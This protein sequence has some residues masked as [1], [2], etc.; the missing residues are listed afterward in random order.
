[1]YG[2]AQ[3]SLA[4]ALEGRRDQ[5]IVAT[6]IWTSSVEEGKRQLGH[7]LEWYGHVESRPRTSWRR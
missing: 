7:Q 4:S 3:R 2:A 1:M 5:A 6:K